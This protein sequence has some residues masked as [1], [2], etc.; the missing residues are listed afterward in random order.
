MQG[1]S[2]VTTNYSSNRFIEDYRFPSLEKQTF[3][4]LIPNSTQAATNATLP[5]Y[6]Y[7]VDYVEEGVRRTG[8]FIKFFTRPDILFSAMNAPPTITSTNSAPASV[9]NNNAINGLQ[10]VGLNGPGVIQ[11]SGN[12]VFG[13]NKLGLHWDLNPTFFLNEEN[14]EPGWIWGHYDGSMGEPMVFPD[15][16]TIRDLERQIY[17]GGE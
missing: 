17:S 2:L 5:S 15:S 1:D 8:T 12:M 14:Q 7:N 9:V 6:E 3:T 4:Y 11:A 10:T 13:F 16:Q